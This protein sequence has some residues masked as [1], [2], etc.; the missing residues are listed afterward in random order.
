MINTWSGFLLP[1]ITVWIAQWFNARQRNM[2]VA[3]AEREV[4]EVLQ[5]GRQVELKEQQ[6]SRTTAQMQELNQHTA[7]SSS[8]IEDCVSQMQEA[9]PASPR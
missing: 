1:M 3:E 8:Q 6:L 7:V 2:A 5:S 9:E 4:E